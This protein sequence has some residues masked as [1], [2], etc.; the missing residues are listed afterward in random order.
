MLTFRAVE[1]RVSIVRAANTGFSGF[2]GRDGRILE[3]TELFTEAVKSASVD[4]TKWKTLYTEWGDLFAQFCFGL[5]VMFWGYAAFFR[6]RKDER[7]AG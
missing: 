4:L 7:N 5:T 1:N 6:R 3:R 2:I